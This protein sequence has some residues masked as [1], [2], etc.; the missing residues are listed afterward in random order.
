MPMVRT[1]R[2]TPGES[3]FALGSGSALD[4]RS[5]LEMIA[6]CFRHQHPEAFGLPPV[7]GAIVPAE[8]RYGR[9]DVRPS[10]PVEMLVEEVMGNPRAVSLEEPIHVADAPNRGL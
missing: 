7:P 2:A 4:S 3:D 1:A 8:V 5:A 10:A 6:D 9:D